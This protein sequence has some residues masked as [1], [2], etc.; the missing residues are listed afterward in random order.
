MHAHF[1]ADVQD[2]VAVMMMKRPAPP[3]RSA[4]WMKCLY[5]GAPFPDG[6][7]VVVDV[8]KKVNNAMPFFILDGVEESF[9]ARGECGSSYV[10]VPFQN[11]PEVMMNVPEKANSTR[12]LSLMDDIFILHPF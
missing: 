4:C 3:Y 11:S 12:Q 2:S 9:E 5:F 8:L 7:E 1:G 6:L 10:G